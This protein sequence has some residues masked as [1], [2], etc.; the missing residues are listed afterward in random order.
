MIPAIITL[1]A[2]IILLCII[3][4]FIARYMRSIAFDITKIRETVIVW[5]MEH[6]SIK[7]L[8]EKMYIMAY[9]VGA[10]KFPITPKTKER[11]K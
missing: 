5:Q 4:V 6:S 1:T 9:D 7:E 11:G 3:L 10:E 8:L 2:A